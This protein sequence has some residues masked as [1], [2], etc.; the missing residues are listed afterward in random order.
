MKKETPPVRR[1]LANNK[2]KKLL[3]FCTAHRAFTVVLGQVTFTDTDRG[4][5][6]FYQFVVIDELQSLL[7]GHLNRR[8]QNRC[9]VSTRRTH[10]GQFLTGQAVYRQVVGTAVNTDDLAFVNFSAVAEEQLTAIL[11]TEQRERYRFT[12]TVGDQYAVV[13][14]AT[15]PGRT[16]S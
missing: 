9:F 15:S 10:V 2:K 5:S 6:N 12:L 4:R 14:L 8:N 7:Q 11:Q 16:S 3:F 1:G 13:T